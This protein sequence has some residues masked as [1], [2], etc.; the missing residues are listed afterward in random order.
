M[1]QVM[2]SMGM[3]FHIKM[4]TDLAHRKLS[5]LHSFFV[6]DLDSFQITSN[7]QVSL[8]AMLFWTGYVKIY[9][10]VMHCLKIQMK[11]THIT[12]TLNWCHDSRSCV[13]TGQVSL[14]VIQIPDTRMNWQ[15]VRKEF[16][17]PLGK[18]HS[19]YL[20]MSYFCILPIRATHKGLKGHTG[21][22]TP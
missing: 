3:W 15:H 20:P 1:Y 6:I 2:I 14:R 10:L 13:I 12:F 8:D 11:N 9:N 17:F 22:R 16:P 4:K 7:L 5:T 18:V 19:P 21:V